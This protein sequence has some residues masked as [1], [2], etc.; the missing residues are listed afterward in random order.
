M[1]FLPTTNANITRWFFPNSTQNHFN[2][3]WCLLVDRHFG[4]GCTKRWFSKQFCE[5]NKN[6]CKF[7]R[8]ITPWKA[9][10]LSWWYNSSNILLCG[11]HF[12]SG[13]ANVDQYV[14][15]WLLVAYYINIM[16]EIISDNTA[17][18]YLKKTPNMK[19]KR[20]FW[21]N[22]AKKNS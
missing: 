19:F 2:W 18:P 15:L 17:C 3:V 21:L 4:R 14:N 16:T 6:I 10:S 13:Y 1:F 22:W 5:I 8:S 11:E 12:C 9:K 20:H 7:A